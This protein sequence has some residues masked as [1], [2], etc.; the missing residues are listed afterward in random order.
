MFPRHTLENTES[1]RND[2]GKQTLKK[3][4]QK[5]YQKYLT[6]QPSHISSTKE[7]DMQPLTRLFHLDIPRFCKIGK[8][9]MLTTQH[10]T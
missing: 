6:P 8:C 3:K 2:E 5:A 10:H 1:V 7:R 4:S 9:K